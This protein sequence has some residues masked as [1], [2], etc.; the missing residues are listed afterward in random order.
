MLTQRWARRT[1]PLT[2]LVADP[3]VAV[4]GRTGA[5]VLSR[6]GVQVSRSTLSAA[7]VVGLR[8]RRSCCHSSVHGAAGGDAC[9]A[10]N[11][12]GWDKMWAQ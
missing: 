2:A 7:C 8:R 6:L 5:A 4:A 10:A 9:R 12:T 3:G 1:R 11:S